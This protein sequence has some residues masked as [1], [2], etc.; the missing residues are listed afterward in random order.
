MPPFLCL[1]CCHC[2]P[3]R[4]LSKKR[5][6]KPHHGPLLCSCSPLVVPPSLGC[7]VHHHLCQYLLAMIAAQEMPPFL[8]P[9]SRHCLHYCAL[10]KKKGHKPHCG[11]VLC[12]C[13]PRIVLPSIQCRIHHRFCHHLLAMRG[14]E[15]MPPFLHHH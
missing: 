2:L 11:G 3:H 5:G 13:S 14:A 10:S 1:N 4:A 9:H 12:S 15:E 6:H 7:C 8:C